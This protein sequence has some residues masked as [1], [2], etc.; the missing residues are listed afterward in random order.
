MNLEK[1]QKRIALLGDNEQNIR[2]FVEHSLSDADGLVYACLNVDVMLPWTNA[3]C[4]KQQHSFILSHVSNPADYV[5]YED[6]LMATAEYALSEVL[7]YEINGQLETLASATRRIGTLLRVFDEGD[8]YEK[9]YLPK[10]FG[11]MAKA[12]YSHEISIDQYIKTIYALNKFHAYANTETTKRI[13]SRI[14]DSADYFLA[15][16]FKHPRRESMI[17]TV[18]NRP[19]CLALYV[20]MLQLAANISG[21]NDY[22]DSMQSERFDEAFTSL[23]TMAP[24]PFNIAS[25]LIEGFHLAQSEGCTDPRLEQIIQSQWKMTCSRFNDSGLGLLYADR[26]LWSSRGLR[27]P[28]Y[29]PLITSFFPEALELALSIL[30]K[31]NQPEQM[32]HINCGLSEDPVFKDRE[33]LSKSICGIS[34]TSWLVAYQRLNLLLKR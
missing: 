25:L 28:A 1:L 3:E 30:E 10:P 29:A 18:E 2:A 5:A 16:D 22:L 12:A 27:V 11:G 7:R 33:Y 34:V 23:K 13:E 26:H 4:E 31:V 14:V 21:N 15:R 6:S 17:V 9:G 24:P 32:L 8:K 19:H 20:P